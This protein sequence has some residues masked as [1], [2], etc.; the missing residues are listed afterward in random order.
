MGRLGREEKE[1]VLDGELLGE[2]GEDKV[3]KCSVGLPGFELEFKVERE[4]DAKSNVGGSF[5][6]HGYKVRG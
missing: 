4:R 2:G 3:L 1:R 5:L 6:F